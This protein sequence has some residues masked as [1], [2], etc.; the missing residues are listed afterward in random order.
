MYKYFICLVFSMYALAGVRAQSVQINA[1]FDTTAITI[2]DQIKFRMELERGE[3]VRVQF[4]VWA[5]TL[6]KNIEII[7]VYPVDSGKTK[8]GMMRYVQDIVITSFDSG[9][10]VLPPVPVP[11]TEGDFSDTIATRPL[12]L[13]VHTLSL[14]GLEDIAD[15]KPIYAVPLTWAEVWPWLLIALASLALAAFIAYA[16]IRYINNKPIFSIAVKPVEPPHI[17]ALRELDKLRN[18]KL[19]QNRKIK[20]YYTRLMDIIRIYIE[21]RFD[22]PAMEMTSDEILGGLQSTGFEDNNLTERLRNVFYR[23]D[24]VKFAKAEPLPDEN[25]S[26][27]LDC[28]LF[29]NNTKLEVAEDT[30]KKEDSVDTPTDENASKEIFETISQ[31]ITKNRT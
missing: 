19:W 18:E 8:N 13:D 23:A 11:F 22:V 24:L 2:G 9:R 4:P 5:D 15:V 31:T 1:K 29:V 26:S 25:E 3:N 27:M 10:H 6:A 14:D 28:Y 7:E 30:G 20:D 16:V 17:I 21:N 12:Y